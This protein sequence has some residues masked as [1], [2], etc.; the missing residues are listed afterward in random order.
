MSKQKT[1]EVDIE[2]GSGVMHLRLFEMPEVLSCTIRDL[3]KGI[4]QS[5]V[6]QITMTV[7]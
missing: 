4:D 6:A 5:Q 2:M 3:L 7:Q 1:L